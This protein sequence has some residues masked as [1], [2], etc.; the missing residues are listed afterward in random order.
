MKKTFFFIFFSYFIFFFLIPL[1]QTP[2]ELSH[3]DTIYWS[4]YGTYPLIPPNE[5]NSAHPGEAQQSFYKNLVLQ[6]NVIPDFK[7]IQSNSLQKQL[8]YTQDEKNTYAPLAGQSYNP[9]LYYIVAGMFLWFARLF[10]TNL[11]MQFYA[12]RLT[13]TLFYFA[14]IFVVYKIF[15]YLFKKESTANSLTIFFGLN[16][17]LIQC[18]IGINTDISITFFTTLFFYLAIQFKKPYTSNVILLGLTTGLAVLSRITGFILIPALTV[19]LYLE[20]KNKKKFLQLFGL[21][22]LIFLCTQIPWSLLN[23]TRY[24]VPIIIGPPFGAFA[25]NGV[26]VSLP[27]AII[28]SLWSFRHIFMHYSGFLGWNDVFPFSPIFII[29]TVLFLLFFG[30]GTYA[31]WRENKNSN[32]IMILSIG[33][34]FLL[35]LFLDVGRKM[36]N[37]QGWETSG[38]NAL[39]IFFPLVFF[40]IKG[41]S[42]VFRKNVD[43]IAIYFSYFAIWYYYFILIFVLLPRYYV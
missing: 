14:T 1:F 10:H 40:V 7:K 4:S 20:I 12:V 34:L 22:M 18:G 6:G 43:S 39:L 11:F 17:F 42:V 3:F 19:F 36:Y 21:Y 2:D 38:R 27:T 26:F 16:P 24:N 28:S 15:R 13:S 30:V 41:V 35:F 33:F 9:P 23:Y 37:H 31:S 25:S 32:K 29:Y 8:D 5:G